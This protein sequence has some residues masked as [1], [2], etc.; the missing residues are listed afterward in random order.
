MHWVTYTIA[1]HRI[2]SSWC[3]IETILNIEDFQRNPNSSIQAY[4]PYFYKYPLALDL[5]YQVGK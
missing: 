4:W 1:K 3:E 2:I 5:S